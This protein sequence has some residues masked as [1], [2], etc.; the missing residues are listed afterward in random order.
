LR[1]MPGEV[2]ISDDNRDFKTLVQQS[3]NCS[4]ADFQP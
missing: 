2:D 1:L 4:I 3:P